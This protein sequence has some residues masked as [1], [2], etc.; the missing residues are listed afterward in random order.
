MLDFLYAVVA[1]GLILIPAII[2][3]ELGH[4][5]AAKAVGINVLEFGVG[6][7]PRMMRLFRWGETD[8]TLNWLPI[9]GY[10]L[11][12][13]EDMIGPADEAQWR[14]KT[15]ADDEP[16]A[17]PDADDAA[18]NKRKHVP[19]HEEMSDREK[20]LARGVPE[21][22]L[23]SVNEAKPVP[24][25][26]FMAAGAFANFVSA[27]LLFIIVAVT[28]I[29]QEVGAR[30]QIVAYPENS[31]YAQQGVE[32]G[33]AVEL[34][35]GE[36]F[37]SMQD[38]IQRLET[39]RGEDVTLTMR[40]LETEENYEI[41]VTPQ[42][43]SARGYVFVSGVVEG[44]PA[45]AAGLQ[46]GDLIT[47]FNGQELTAQEDPRNDLQRLTAENL[48]QTVTL[49]ILRDGNTLTVNLVPRED[50][51]ANQGAMGILIDAQYVTSDNVRY[52][53][54]TAQTKL[55]P[56]SIGEAIPYGVD[57]LFTTLQLIISIPAQLIEGTLSPEQARPV[58]VIGIS[59]VGGQFLQESIRQGNPFLILNFVA[60]VSIFLG[61]TNLLPLPPLDGG[62]ILFVLIEVVRGK[63]VS[64]Q[65]EA[66]IY[67]I[68]ITLLLGL[69]VIVILY[70]IFN[71]LTLPT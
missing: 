20:L 8:F 52:A 63:P 35:N 42:V 26:I 58:S 2:I 24:R 3:H 38:F 22:K 60:L 45:E 61:F 40:N 16:A 9:G 33:D 70:D 65:I 43:S 29:P 31:M 32:P 28:G 51:P 50:P 6:F 56:M 59:Q 10:V 34:I 57:R 11:P 54:A 71:P 46:K 67:R 49:T 4:F 39:L 19:E 30:N 69:A 1:F 36:Y 55:I 47:A 62:R 12:L 68:G 23:L 17:A 5:L 15:E 18:S 48:G 64:P 53:I 13:G 66:A 41:Q 44:A 27:V 7:P 21:D 14:G 25:I 37:N